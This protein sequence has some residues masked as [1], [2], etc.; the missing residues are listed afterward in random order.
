METKPT[1]RIR[2][3]ENI[4]VELFVNF[5][6][7]TGNPDTF[8]STDT[9]SDSG[10]MPV[11][12][13][14]DSAYTF[15]TDGFVLIGNIGSEN[16]ELIQLHA[17]TPSTTTLLTFATNT[18]FAHSRG[19]QIIFIPYS[20]F[21]VY[22]STNGGSSYSLLS[23]QSIQTD[24]V[25]GY[26]QDSV[27]TS[28]DY[29]KVQFKND[30]TSKVS[31]FSDPI[32]GTG[33]AVNSAGAVIRN[34]LLSLGEKKDEVLTQEF[35]YNCLNEGR[36]EID[37][38]I[39]INRWSFRT[40]FDYDAGNVIA[41]TNSISVPTDLRDPSTFKNI[42]SVRIGRDRYLL[43]QVDKK[44]LDLNYL[45]VAHTTLNGTVADSDVSIV[46]T[47]S[48]DF[49]DSSTISVASPDVSSE[50]DYIPYTGNTLATNT[51]TGVTDIATG[52]HADGV[53]VWQSATF[54]FP[55]QYTVYEE[56]IVFSQPFSND[57][58]GENIW[59]DYYKELTD[60]NSDGDLLDEPFYKIYI[61][62]MRYRIKARRNQELNRDA[63]NDYRSWIE[64]RETM[65]NKEFLG[66]DI[67]ISIDTPC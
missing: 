19:E 56:K 13:G 9:D 63:D 35:L 49:D 28:T 43:N 22:K 14:S 40:S 54:G 45:G 57:I 7:L 48:G 20:H 17:S 51:I 37:K 24:K 12:S 8:I 21:D 47:S 44:D 62:Y 18:I 3:G 59:L 29:Y 64:K 46:L 55:L 25:E 5:P 67:R 36:D 27:G 31:E 61:P 53:D 2:I 30:T 26:Y 66:Q 65:V 10:T 32:I 1:F 38:H 33:F 34:A 60:I 23:S 6:D 41:G 11:I 4:G 52:G 42:L 50:I 16:S 15:P 39:S 58:S